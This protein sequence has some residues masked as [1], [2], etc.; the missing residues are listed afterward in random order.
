MLIIIIYFHVTSALLATRSRTVAR[1]G[2]VL[3]RFPEFFPYLNN[4]LIDFCDIVLGLDIT[5]NVI[6]F[7]RVK[8]WQEFFVHV[9][10]YSVA[11]K[12]MLLSVQR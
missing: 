2:R 11:R 8:C 5:K 1:V 6:V 3:G 12:C 7:D 9:V 10:Y 4:V